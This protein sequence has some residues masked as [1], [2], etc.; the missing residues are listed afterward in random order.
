MAISGRRHRLGLAQ[1]LALAFVGLV[2]F[3]LVVNGALSMWLSYNEARAAAVRVQQEKAEAAA[4]RVEQ[5][6]TEIEGQLGWTTRAEWE[7]VSLDQRRYD[8]IRLLRQVPAITELAYIDGTGHEQLK[9][10]RLELDVVG[11]GADLSAEPRFRDA[12]AQHVWYGPVTFRRG[13]EPY[14]TIAVAHAGRNPGVTAAEVN[15][16]LIWD[17]LTA[18]RVGQGGYAYVTDAHGRLIAHPDM[19][20]VLRDTDL[21]RLPQ[22]AAAIADPNE[23][24]RIA[25]TMDGRSMLSAHAVVPKLG[26]IVFV[27]L[28]TREALAPVY[29]ALLQSALLL[30]LGLLVAAVM[31]TALAR[32]MVG[33][34]RALQAGAERLGEGDLSQRI[35][36]H[37]G[38]EIET[39]ADRFNQ[40]ASRIQESYETLEAQVEA[41]THDLN[42]SLHQQTAT[43]EVLK[44]ISR[45][46]FDL[47]SV[48]NTLIESA[49]R[50]CNASQGFVSLRDGDLIRARAQYGAT[51]EFFAFLKHNPFAAG[52]RT[53]TGRVAMTGM[54]HNVAD[55]TV[56]PEFDFPG[57]SEHGALRSVLGVP[58]LRAGQVEG[59]LVLSRPESRPFTPRQVELVTTFADQAVIAVE[60]ARL[61]DE[62]QARTRDLTE[63]LKYQSATADVLKS[64]SR[65]AFDLDTVLDTLTRSAAALCDATTG[66]IR[67]RHGDGFRVGAVFGGGPEWMKYMREQ[68]LRARPRIGL[69]AGRAVARGRAGRGHAGGPGNAAG[70]ANRHSKP[71]RTGRTVAAR[72]GI[73]GRFRTWTHP[74][75]TL[76]RTPDRI[77]TNLRR[78]GPDRHRERPPVQRGASAHR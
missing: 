48:L 12:V 38:D 15:L 33:P 69:V 72:W 74:A 55:T 44:V 27:E 66:S 64:I 37:T 78:P 31:G 76:H 58:L 4:E 41:R 6:I 29:A 50:L 45:S 46:A 20:L 39:L 32:R 16:K 71:R 5:F 24:T 59:V 13:S 61:F 42:E 77:G 11:S 57:M 63:A 17:V 19:S 47:Q 49:V 22:V 65:S 54:V 67:L 2:T 3:V 70:I 26:W 34:I 35:A 21:A 14:M 7:R 52:R 51:P 75:R 8:F 53:V 60:N 56:D 9:L 1:K 68:P 73:G 28:P 43:A 30:G 40:M 36:V 62:V 23:P 25:Y 18:L 10:S